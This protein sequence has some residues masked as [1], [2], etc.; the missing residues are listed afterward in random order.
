MN[1]YQKDKDAE[2]LK[3]KTLVTTGFQKREKEE[4]QKIEDESKQALEKNESEWQATTKTLAKKQKNNTI[5]ETED[6]QDAIQRINDT[7]KSKFSLEDAEVENLYKNFDKD[8]SGILGINE[9]KDAFKQ[10]AYVSKVKKILEGKGYEE[11][12]EDDVSNYVNKTINVLQNNITIAEEAQKNLFS[13]N[14]DDETKGALGR[15]V[16]QKK[17][18]ES[19]YQLGKTKIIGEQTAKIADVN[20]R[21]SETN[22][23]TLLDSVA[24]KTKELQNNPGNAELQ[25]QIQLLINTGS[26]SANVTE[27]QH[28]Q[29]CVANKSH[30]YNGITYN[31]LA[32]CNLPPQP[33]ATA[34][35]RRKSKRSQKKNIN[36]NKRRTHKSRR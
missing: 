1:E 23:N 3:N 16:L 4:K 6:K 32:S 21:Y 35:G 33:V 28:K 8:S 11:P 27:E 7:I 14:N 24:K 10:P 19:K 29:L 34:A 15:F 30:V 18:A 22:L 36:G 13:A 20:N 25:Q 12:D 9:L 5:Q 17:E 2:V 31:D 26:E